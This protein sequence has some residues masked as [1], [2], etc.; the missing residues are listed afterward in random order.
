M[1]RPHRLAGQRRHRHPIRLV[2]TL[3][4]SGGN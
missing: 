4:T 1:D 2:L 3:M